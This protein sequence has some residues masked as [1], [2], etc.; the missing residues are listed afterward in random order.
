M[1]HPIVELNSLADVRA[2][3][4]LAFAKSSDSG[5]RLRVVDKVMDIHVVEL[6]GAIERD[7]EELGGV[8]LMSDRTCHVPLA[9]D[10]VA[11][12]VDSRD[13]QDDVFQRREDSSVTHDG[14]QVYIVFRD[15]FSAVSKDDCFG[16]IPGE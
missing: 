12:L 16:A 7:T 1:E 13:G 9:G 14:T 4:R 11:T 15:S 8:I 10:I 3:D 6:R 5:R 2:R